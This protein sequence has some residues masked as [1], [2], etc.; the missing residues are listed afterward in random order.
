MIGAY[1]VLSFL[2]AGIRKL[3]WSILGKKHLAKLDIFEI[4]LLAEYDTKYI[5][6]KT[7]VREHSVKVGTQLKQLNWQIISDT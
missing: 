5:N 1:I 2:I 6:L 3:R 7:I 4:I